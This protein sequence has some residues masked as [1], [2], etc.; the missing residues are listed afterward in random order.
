MACKLSYD[1]H[2]G[3][4]IYV[5]M[6]LPFDDGSGTPVVL[7]AYSSR[8]LAEARCW[9]EL[10]LLGYHQPTAVYECPLDYAIANAEDGEP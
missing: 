3:E 2:K 4:P 9:R 6:L 1:D 5:A 8:P 10:Q 7:G